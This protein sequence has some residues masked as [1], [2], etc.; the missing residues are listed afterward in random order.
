MQICILALPTS[1]A[2]SSSLFYIYDE[3]T[4]PGQEQYSILYRDKKS[5][6]PRPNDK[7]SSHDTSST[8]VKKDMMGR[9]NDIIA[10]DMRDLGN[11]LKALKEGSFARSAAK[12][13]F[14]SKREIFNSGP[15]LQF[16]P[17]EEKTGFWIFLSLLQS[18][19]ELPC[20]KLGKWPQSLGGSPANVCLKFSRAVIMQL[21]VRITVLT[22]SPHRTNEFRTVFRQSDA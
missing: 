12:S 21:A 4:H 16:K 11:V 20:L 7:G 10:G 9:R 8:V 17:A 15:P 14:G 18:W 2:F 22:T 6:P 1:L 13:H 3:T 5:P 19:P